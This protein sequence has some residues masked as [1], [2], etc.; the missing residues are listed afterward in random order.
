MPTAP[1]TVA[2]FRAELARLMA[3]TTA[4]PGE[5]P[6]HTVVFA[7]DG[8]NLATAQRCWPGAR[9]R[10]MRSVTP[11][12][13][14]ACWLS[15]LTGLDTAAHGVPGVVFADPSGGPDL[16]NFLAYAG[17]GLAPDTGTVF[18][19][20][21]RLGRRPLALLGDM[22]HY[23]SAWR[24]ALLQGAEPI[25]GHTFYTEA[26][27]YRPRPATDIVARVRTAVEAALDRYG[28]QQSCLIWCYIEV[29]Q[30]VHRHGYDRHT[31]DVLTALDDWARE[32]AARGT[33][34]V[35]HA[36]HGLVP[37][38]HDEKRAALLDQL[39]QRYGFRMGGAGRMRWLYPTPETERRELAAVLRELLPYDIRVMGAD[40]VF[41]AGSAARAR[42]GDV[43]LVAEGERFLT[44]PDYRYDH[45]SFAP[46]E[47]DTPFAVWR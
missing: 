34:V 11:T 32:L 4:P 10:L 15:A 16:V 35:A 12:T 1:L 40:D 31:T 14:S 18:H 29:D 3:A 42:V 43:V 19:D 6:P 36:D 46:E 17:P 21:A 8:V 5:Q 9:T 2:D 44:D 13:S 41:P 7:L 26:G 47:T 38:V 20:A 39:G 24:D 28:T 33:L 25:T 23:G 37:T 22:E 27:T 45:G 30:H